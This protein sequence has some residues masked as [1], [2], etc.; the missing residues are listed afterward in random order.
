MITHE[1]LLELWE[2]DAFIDRSNL[3]AT[4]ADVPKLHHK[5]LR[6]YM[7]LKTKKIAYSHKLESIRKDKELYYT[8]QATSDEYKDKPFD[9]KLKTKSGIEK[10]INTDPEVVKLLQR[11]EYMDIL[12]EGVSHILDQIKWRNQSIRSA[13][14]WIKFTS[15]EL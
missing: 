15:G 5:Y 6:I 14:D 11:I 4:A 2:K 9:L 1:E 12:L 13:I 10:H 8:G 7:D 3:D